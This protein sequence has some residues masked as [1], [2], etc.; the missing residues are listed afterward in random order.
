M[1]N[2]TLTAMICD[3]RWSYLG[4]H[5]TQFPEKILPFI[6]TGNMSSVDPD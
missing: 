5:C 6:L 2:N 3:G 1:G 4:L